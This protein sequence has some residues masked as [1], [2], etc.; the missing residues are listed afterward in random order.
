MAATTMSSK[1]QIVIPEEIRK[2][3]DLKPRQ[4][5]RVELTS[6]GNVLVI[7]VPLDAIAEMKLE[8]ISQG[9]LSTE[10]E[11]VR[12]KSEGRIEEVSQRL[13]K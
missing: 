2:K 3:L 9:E 10:L 8:G 12:K 6:R 7:P 4:R 1:G 5:F 11:N 13:K